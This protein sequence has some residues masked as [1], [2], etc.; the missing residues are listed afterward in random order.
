[1]ETI[2]ITTEKALTGWERLQSLSKNADIPK[3]KVRYAIARSIEKLKSALDPV[4]ENNKELHKKY[5]D[6]EGKLREKVSNEDLE[7]ELKIINESEIEIE[8]YKFKL[9][10]LEDVKVFNIK[11]EKVPMAAEFIISLEPWIIDDFE[12][13]QNQQEKPDIPKRN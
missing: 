5:F 12:E 3:F 9:S 2:T 13:M 10:D 6:K 4:F 11:N 1:M 7:A 8:V